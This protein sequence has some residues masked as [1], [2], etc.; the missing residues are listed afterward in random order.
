MIPPQNNHKIYPMQ[1]Y[2][3]ILLS[4]EISATRETSNVSFITVVWGY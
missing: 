4:P 1:F 3:H 2:L